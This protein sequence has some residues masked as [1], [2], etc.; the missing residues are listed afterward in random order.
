[1]KKYIEEMIQNAHK[2]MMERCFKV[3]CEITINKKC[4]YCKD[5]GVKYVGVKLGHL[6]CPV[7]GKM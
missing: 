5:L 7:C 3:D 2:E 6:R 1:M 4:E